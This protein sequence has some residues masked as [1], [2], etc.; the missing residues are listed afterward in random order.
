MTDRQNFEQAVIFAGGRGERLRPLTDTLPKPMAPVHGRPFSDYL[1]RALAAAGIRRV[2]ILVGYKAEKF[3]DYYADGAEFGINIDYSLGQEDDQ[4]G[5]RLL[6]AF[7]KLEDRFLLLYGDNYWPVPLTGMAANYARLG[8]P[9]TT[10]V[11]SNRHGTGEYGYENNVVVSPDWTV[12][13]YDKSRK[14]PGL[15]GVDI[16]FFLVDKRVLDPRETGNISFEESI[17]SQLAAQGRLG[18]FLTEEQYYYITSLES[19]SR[20]EQV[21]V[22]KGFS[23]MERKTQHGS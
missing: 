21:V 3:M 17:L 9:V 15:N 13:A 4:T 1:I 10:T 18:A 19:L 5:R 11:F 2:L 20:F 16:G 12:K 23:P 6:N 22:Q 7:S 8:R 14:A